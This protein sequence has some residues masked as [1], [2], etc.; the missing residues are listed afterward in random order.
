M[1]HTM[2]KQFLSNNRSKLKSSVVSFLYAR[3]IELIWDLTFW[4]IRRHFRRHFSSFCSMRSFVM[5][6]L[7]WDSWEL[8]L[9]VFRMQWLAVYLR[10]IKIETSFWKPTCECPRFR[11]IDIDCTCAVES[12]DGI[13]LTI[14]GAVFVKSCVL[15]ELDWAWFKNRFGAKFGFQWGAYNI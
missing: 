4:V 14:C 6:L 9:L 15:K 5:G 10:P 3:P 12:V 7:P 13:I 8:L 1:S 2:M 11:F